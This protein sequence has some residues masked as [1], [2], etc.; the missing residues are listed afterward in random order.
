ML[1]IVQ[2]ISESVNTCVSVRQSREMCTYIE[3][4]FFFRLTLVGNIH[5]HMSITAF[6][7]LKEC[8]SY[9]AF[10]FLIQCNNCID[11]F[12]KCFIV[13]VGLLERRQGE[14]VGR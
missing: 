14:K 9:S 1:R 10:F 7:E 4:V 11:W 3:G 12:C 2:C 8:V 6:S 5:L 13:F